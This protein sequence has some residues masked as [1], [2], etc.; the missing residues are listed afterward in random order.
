MAKLVIRKVAV[1]GAGVMG[2]QIAAHCIN[3][4]V[5]VV[6]FDLPAK[7][8]LK[9]G[10]VLRA[11][12]Q[13]NKLKPAPLSLSDDAAFIEPANYA[14]DLEKLR[15][16]DL[17][18]EAVAERVDIK[19]DLYAKVGPYVSPQAIFATNTSGLSINAL[20]Q[21]LEKDLRARFCGVHFF[22]P[23]RY[24]HLVELIAAEDT[25]LQILDGLEAF[26]TSVLGKGVV[27][28]LDTPNFIANRVGTFSLLAT[29]AEAERFK[30]TFDVVDDLTGKK[31]GRAKS[32][33]FRTADVVGLDTFGHVV[34]TMQDALGD[35]PFHHVYAL[36]AV[37]KTLIERGA[38]G[39][40]TRVG[41]YK[42]EGKNILQLD[43]E[44]GNYVPTGATADEDV[45]QI[46][47]Q[48]EPGERLRQLRESQNPQAQF[49]WAILRDV[50]HYSAVHVGSIAAS[51]REVDFALRWGFG[52]REGPFEL[53][54][55]AGW[56]R[57]AS[58]VSED[59]E[60][61]KALAEVPL[62]KWVFEGK[63]RKAGGVHTPAGS[64]SAAQDSFVP[65][66]QL[67]AY[68]RQVFRAGLFGDGAPSAADAG[69]SVFEDEAVRLWTLD[70]EALVLSIKTKMHTVSPAVTDGIS[71][72]VEQAEA[73]FGAL[74][75]Y[76]QDEPFSAGADLK[77]MM[78]LFA[79]GDFAAIE[80]AI[81][82]LQDAYLS[83]RYCQVPTVAAVRGLALG[84]GCELA[85]ACSRRVAHIETYIG[86]VE[87]GVGLVPG[88]GGLLYGARRASEEHALAPSASL[89]SFLSKYF[90]AAAMAKVST[91]APE[92]RTLGYLLPSD[93]IVYN[94][95]ELLSAA[96]REA[97]CLSEASYR[98]PLKPKG[99][100]VAG[101][102]AASTILG[103]VVNLR[104]GGFISDHDYYLGKTVAEVLCGGDVEPGSRVDEAWML[105]LERKAFMR[106]LQNP[107]SQERIVG[108]M[109]TGKPVR[110]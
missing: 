78:P 107:K 76:S 57:V 28:A 75:I 108:M 90:E 20:A 70:D 53:W 100:E 32:G 50:F 18:I 47:K 65:R 12:A 9:N 96:L 104:E 15:S 91:S 42:K 48:A 33:T 98:P 105:A 36:P 67:S 73:N 109:Q 37:V 63:A 58:L 26:L 94:S 4:K 62:P 54:Q 19:R 30:L 41:F 27:R 81:K 49:L 40:K 84:G 2:A 103:Q 52:W 38:L 92:G 45:A 93:P 10:I 3:A 44:S 87:V 34:K 6:L 7:E 25:K 17:V 1:L 68:R 60:A 43:Q 51:A 46:L 88:A 66:T 72:A 95:Y 14:E 13:L 35:D 71:K 85:I 106:L 61:G 99:F 79:A 86:L 56:D 64:Y 39:Q 29:I 59:I 97:R 82:A 8:G 22:N 102:S 80:Q 83:L 55:A 101:R 16:C 5:P 24:M 31:L 77:S 11:I 110:N 89:L 69:R 74:V 21:S 23:P